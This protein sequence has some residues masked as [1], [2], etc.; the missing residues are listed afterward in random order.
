VG[1]AGILV[2][3]MLVGLAGLPT[4]EGSNGETHAARNRQAA[5]PKESLRNLLFRM[6]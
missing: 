6:V 3:G 5:A 2:D 4:T 1:V